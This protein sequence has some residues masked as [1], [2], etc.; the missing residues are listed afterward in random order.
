MDEFL[1]FCLKTLKSN[2]TNLDLLRPNCSVH[3]IPCRFCSS[4]N[5]GIRL[6]DWF[7]MLNQIKHLPRIAE[8]RKLF[9]TKKC[10]TYSDFF[11]IFCE[12]SNPRLIIFCTTQ[13]FVRS[14]FLDVSNT[15]RA[16]FCRRSYPTILSTGGACHTNFWSHLLRNVIIC[17]F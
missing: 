12:I 17:I 4:N 6:F 9:R 8:Q 10:V 5:F 16:F 2:L 1:L 14:S 15:K 3:G 13:I 7:D 11:C